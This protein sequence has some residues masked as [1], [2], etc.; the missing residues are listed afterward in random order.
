MICISGLF[1]DPELSS[2]TCEGLR[3][4]VQ[5]QLDAAKVACVPMLRDSAA[6]YS[7]HDLLGSIRLT[8]ECALPDE[9]DH[10]QFEGTRR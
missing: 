2:R 6:S 9:Q 8:A 3:A 5:H 10:R 1:Y 7:G 4:V